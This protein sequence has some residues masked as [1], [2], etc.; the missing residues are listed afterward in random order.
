MDARKSETVVK[1]VRTILK[2]KGLEHL[3]VGGAGSDSND[4][5]EL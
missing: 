2:K 5:D 4:H 1:Y 3:I